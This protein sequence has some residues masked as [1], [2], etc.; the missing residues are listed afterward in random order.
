MGNKK[1]LLIHPSKKSIYG[2]GYSEA[3]KKK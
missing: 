1:P 2:S 3:K